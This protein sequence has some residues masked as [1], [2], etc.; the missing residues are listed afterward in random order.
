MAYSAAQLAALEAAIASGQ[1]KVRYADQEVTY[2]SLEA[3][4]SLR[5]AMLREINAASAN[6]HKQPRHQLASF[7]DD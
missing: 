4:Q 5:N 6:P 3:M 7:A 2:Q 1:L